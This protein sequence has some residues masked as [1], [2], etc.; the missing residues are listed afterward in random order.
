VCRAVRGW[1]P[2][3]ERWGVVLVAVLALVPAGCGGDDDS[4]PPRLPRSVA[5]DLAG[6]SEVVAERL[7]AADPCGAA[8]RAR[9]LDRAVEAEIGAGRVPE[10]LRGELRSAVDDLVRGIECP[11]PA[12]Q[13]ERPAGPVERPA[14]PVEPPA[15]ECDALERA[16]DETQPTLAGSVLGTTAYMAPE[17]AAGEQVTGAADIY[18]PGTVPYE[19]L[20]GRRPVSGD[21]AAELVARK[22]AEHL[23]PLQRVAPDTPDGLAASVMSCLVRDPRARPASAAVLARSLAEGLGERPVVA[24]PESTG[25]LAAEVTTAPLPGA[26]GPSSVATRALATARG[27][28][29]RVAHPRRLAAPAVALIV[30][31][32][33]VLALALATGGEEPT[34]NDGAVKVE[35]IPRSDEPSQLARELAKWLRSRSR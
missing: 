35:P 5:Q 4:G 3:N 18:S 28:A 13:G 29:A 25:V 20:A 15:A 17:Q 24:L 16:E 8:Q 23:E 30:L 2:S 6:R 34:T 31:A 7:E 1:W 32:A 14:G 9:A 22:A 19:L 33:A 26:A 27:A 11:A 10:A 21:S 12:A